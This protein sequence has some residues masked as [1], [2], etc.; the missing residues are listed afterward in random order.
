VAGKMASDMCRAAART[1]AT[2]TVKKFVPHCCSVI[3]HLTS[4]EGVAEE[5]E[6]DDQLLWNL[7][8][9]SEVVRSSG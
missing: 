2:A 7:Q 5:E 6:V 3:E 8:I 4:V 1:N 9:V